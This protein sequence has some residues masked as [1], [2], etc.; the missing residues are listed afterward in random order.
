MDIPP[1]P[2]P[3]LPPPSPILKFMLPPPLP[4]FLFSGRC[5]LD[6][7][8][9]LFL[10]FFLSLFSLSFLF[11]SSSVRVGP[12]RC[13]FRSFSLCLSLSLSRAIFFIISASI[14]RLLVVLVVSDVV[15]WFLCNYRI[16]TNLRHAAH[17]VHVYFTNNHHYPSPNTNFSLL[18]L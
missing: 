14:Y 15:C 12:F 13:W 2:Y 11:V 17:T 5:A 8:S 9:G 7:F 1:A 10:H 18:S 6:F 16:I 3:P 4:S